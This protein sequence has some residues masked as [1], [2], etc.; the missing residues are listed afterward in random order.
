[1]GTRINQQRARPPHRFASGVKNAIEV[2]GTGFLSNM[3][4]TPLRTAIESGK[5]DSL[6]YYRQLILL[7]YR[8]IFLFVAEE[9]AALLDPE[10]DELT[11]SRFIADYSTRRLRALSATG[12]DT[13]DRDVW[14]RLRN[15]MLRLYQGGPESALPRYGSFLWSSQTCSALMNA[16]C[17]DEH[18]L[19]AIRYLSNMQDVGSQQISWDSLRADELGRIYERL[20]EFCPRFSNHL[21][22]FHL[23][24]T[25]NHERKATGSYYTPASLVDCLL[26][27][28]LDPVLDDAANKPDP[29]N[30]ILSLKVCDPACGSGNFLIAAARRIGK[31][32]ASIRTQQDEPEPQETRRA[33]G[34]VVGNCIFGVDVDPLSVEICKIGLWL[35]TMNPGRPLALLDSHI[36]CGNALLGTT[37]E[38]VERGI[39]DHE[40]D[41]TNGDHRDD[42]RQ[43]IKQN[44][45]EHRA[46]EV[47]QFMM[48]DDFESEAN[49]DLD[50]ATQDPKE[51][52]NH[53]AVDMTDLRLGQEQGEYLIRRAEYD[54]AWF[55]SDAWCAAFV[56]PKRS[57]RLTAAAITEERSQAPSHSTS[58]VPNVTRAIVD[59]LARKYRFF[60][61][62]LAFAQVFSSTGSHQGTSGSHTVRRGFDVVLGN[63]PFVNSIEG[64][65]SSGAKAIL[66]AVS[67]DLRGTADLAFHFVQLAHRITNRNGRIGFVQPKTFLNAESASV[68]RANLRTQ[69]PPALIYVP[70]TAKY[71]DRAAAYVCLLVLA[72]GD[73]LQVSDS[74]AIDS[75]KWHFGVL[76]DDNWWRSVQVILGNTPQIPSKEV[77]PMGSVFSV[78]ASMTTGDAYTVQPFVRDD[79]HGKE[80][81]LVTTGLIDPFVCKWGKVSCRYLGRVYR[82]PC[83]P[84]TSGLPR[85]LTRRLR[86]ARRPKV[87]IAGLSNRLEAFLDAEGDCCG[88]VS[89]FS[90]F[91]SDDSIDTLS[92]LC[93]W[94]NSEIATSLIRSEL[95]AASVG[96]NYMTIKKQ[97]LIR[98]TVPRDIFR[99]R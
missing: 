97:A 83:V 51:G 93:K 11:K 64:G 71:F 22:S 34:D 33:V 55:R 62:H 95:G 40:S 25:G 16:D 14:N 92:E 94:L 46:I 28:A 8:F 91:D 48:F 45:K 68:L 30:S 77:V 58:T 78:A 29:E 79:I 39:A 87:L 88:A 18:I 1:M 12:L 80:L 81:K 84:Q 54:D 61:W 24:A 35:E 75:A 85:A 47:G 7:I 6:E 2:L 49:E 52:G 98:L 10:A 19:S 3:A 17:S 86:N 32:L 74:D 99:R 96:S 65:I 53:S 57:R 27:S 41:S 63:P 73:H 13:S 9:R 59:E 15:V 5:L 36:Q 21:S 50:S 23:V 60:H 67:P 42:I 4:N 38:L 43:P 66:R 31:R 82:R 69:R 90:V 72:H 37:P 44:R 70:S 26:N 89:T 56:W 76:R 20:L